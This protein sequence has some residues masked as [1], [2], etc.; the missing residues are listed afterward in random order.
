MPLAIKAGGS[1][2]WVLLHVLG[3]LLLLARHHGGASVCS[4]L[5]L[6]LAVVGR[7][8]TCAHLTLLR[9]RHVAIGSLIRASQTVRVPREPSLRM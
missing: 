3:A 7:H 6:P 1:I 2:L 8:L 5:V 9:R 4:R